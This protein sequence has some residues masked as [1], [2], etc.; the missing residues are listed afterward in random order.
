MAAAL[1]DP[2]WGDLSLVNTVSLPHQLDLAPAGS[3]GL[4]PWRLGLLADLGSADETL[5]LVVFT[6]PSRPGAEAA[7]ARLREGWDDP[8]QGSPIDAMLA[9]TPDEAPPARPSLLEITGAPV[10]TGVGGEGPYVAWAALR[11]TPQ[12]RSVTVGSPS[13]DRLVQ[14]LYRRDLVLFG[15]P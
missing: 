10:E 9:G 12:V 13:F 5:T 15:P 14:A 8:G 4:P 11:G 2:A 3:G 7:A 6:Y 1:D